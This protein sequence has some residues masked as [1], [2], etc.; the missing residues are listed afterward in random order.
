MA[1]S[2]ISFNPVV[3]TN[4]AGSFSVQSSGFIAGTAYPDP[5]SRNW[6]NGG[7]LS[8]SET[9]PMWGG[10][11]ITELIPTPGST[12]LPERS[13]GTI[14]GRATNQTAA[15]TGQLTGFSVFD[16][17]HAMVNNPQSPVPLA[18]SGMSVNF[19]RFGSNARI[20]VPCSSALVSI[21]NGVI[22]QQVSWDFA[23]QILVPYTP[24]YSANTI[25]NAVWASTSGGQITFTVSRN[26]TT[27]V[28]AGDYITV[29]SV[30]NTGGSSTT[31]FNGVWYVVSTS[32]TTIVVSAPA[33]ST[34]GTYASGGSVAAVSGGALA[35]KVLDID[36][37]NSMVPVYN[38]T[39]GYATWNR[40]GNCALIMI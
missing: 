10:V 30:V 1:T 28:F 16:Q 36:I 2:N 6:L 3:T 9:L 4:A 37:G 11:G 39:T 14:V 12:T 19:Y 17:A 18:G 40:S 23:N 13:M 5:S 38:S 29:G 33:A 27:E 22:T 8:A 7:I 35:C 15:T 31:A 24:G 20:A 25:T 26:P 34:L 21:E 32:S